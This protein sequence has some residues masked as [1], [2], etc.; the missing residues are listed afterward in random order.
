MKRKISILLVLT[1]ILT[2]IPFSSFAQQNFDKQLKEAIVKSKKLFN[3]GSEYDKFDHYINSYDENTVF[4]LNWSDSKGKLGNI[5]V[6]IT[7]DG[8]VLSYGKW[9][10]YFGDDAPKLPKVS[11]EEG[12]KIAKDFIK[13]VSPEF[14]NNI[15][16]VDNNEIL[17]P[18][19]DSYYYYFVRTI[20]DIPYSENSIDISVDNIT[21]EVKNYY[22]NWDMNIAFLDAKDMISAEKAKELYKEKIGLKLLIK[23]SYNFDLDGQKENKYLAYGPLDTNLGINAKNGE[24][25]FYSNYYRAYDKAEGAKGVEEAE[26]NPDEQEAVDSISGLISKE[27]AEKVGRELLKI[28]SE[29]KI[30]YISLH[31]NWRNKNDYTWNISFIKKVDS[32]DFYASIGI[33]A[34]TKELVQFDKFGYVDPSKKVQYK[35]AEALKIAKE[36]ITK[37]NP[38]KVNLIEY[39]KNYNY[40]IPVEEEQTEY[41]FEFVRKEKD[42]YVVNDCIEVSVDTR[43]GS[44]NEYRISWGKDKL[45]SQEK[46]IAI[47][48]AY[49]ILF[50]EIG[51]ELKYIN[52]DRYDGN[53]STEKKEAILVYGLK[54]EKPANIDANT[55]TILDYQGKPFKEPTLVSYSDIDKSYA[56]EKINILA[57]YGIALP[58]DEFKPSDKMVQSDFLYLLAKANGSYF[59]LDDSKDTIYNYLINMGIVKE[60][61]KAPEKIITKEEAIKYIIRALKYDKVAD[62]N[63]IYKELFKD[64]KDINPELKGY[65]SIAYGLKIVEGNNGYLNPKAELK[66]ED[67]VNMIFNYLFNN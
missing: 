63:E 54:N 18:N 56:K 23:S 65:V 50:N 12:L 49:D 2:F 35:E 34:K 57:Q 47:D 31:K 25:T 3:I 10:P 33:D 60:D 44:I 64:T 58:G 27:E 52:P 11:K 43:D 46:V 62:L 9:K 59:E 38:D 1:M 22:T 5:D 24:V 17:N 39:K 21:G 32:K 28:D 8:T 67:G 37:M 15:Q 19:S 26:L 41:R 51:M 14:A 7:V 13:K 61:E 55:A 29:Y 6:S 53:Y 45:P 48:K 16:Y 66:R 36:Y 42:A 40:Y 4:Y 30:E 20:N